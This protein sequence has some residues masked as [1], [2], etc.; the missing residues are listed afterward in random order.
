MDTKGE[1]WGINI[2]TVLYIKQIINKDQLYST[3]NSTQYS[4]VTYMERESEMEWI[5]VCVQLNHFAVHMKLIQHYKS[6][7]LQYIKK[8]SF[9]KEMGIVVAKWGRGKYG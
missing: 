1:M 9:K 6:I 5:Y 2:Y 4:V 8:L 3:G 7:I